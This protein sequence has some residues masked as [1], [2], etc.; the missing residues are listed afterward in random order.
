[1]TTDNDITVVIPAHPARARNG[2]LLRALNSVLVQTHPAAAVSLAMD[3]HGEGAA[4]TRQR[5]LEAAQT[6][7]VAFLD[8]D[9]FY[10][11][12][13]LER[14]MEHAQETGADFVYSWFEVLGGFDPFPSTHFTNDWNPE[15]PIETTVTTLV[16]T[17]LAK[18]VGFQALDRGEVNSG[19]DRFFTIGC[20]EAGAL[21]SHLKEKTWFYAHHGGNTSGLPNKGDAR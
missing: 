15:D 5:A 10:K 9:D 8:S 3:V 4:K 12:Q 13:H 21:I 18:S 20:M 7:W 17:G 19:E 2:M 6:P 11:P 1:M 16:R 14:M